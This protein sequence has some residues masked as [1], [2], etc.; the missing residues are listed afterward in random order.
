M[1]VRSVR[2]SERRIGPC[3]GD[4]FCWTR[5][6]GECT[7]DDDNREISRTFVGSDLVVF[8]TPVIFGGYSSELKRALDHLIPNISPFFV[9]LGG[10][11][12]TPGATPSIRGSWSWDGAPPKTPWPRASSTTWSHATH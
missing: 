7:Q 5:S 8:L 9:T 3:M 10:R 11:P 4:F 12:I 1:S 6:P 2:V